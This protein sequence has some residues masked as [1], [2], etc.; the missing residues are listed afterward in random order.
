MIKNNRGFTLIEIMITISITVI[1]MGTVLAMLT[2][3][4]KVYNQIDESNSVLNSA[5]STLEMVREMTFN[6]Q[7]IKISNETIV[8]ITDNSVICICAIDNSIYLDGNVVQ[9]AKG[10][11]ADKMELIFS[12]AN[13]NTNDDK[14]NLLDVKLDITD[15][16]N[17]PLIEQQAISLFLNNVENISGDD[18][19]NCIIITKGDGTVT[20]P[21]I[22]DGSGDEA[23]TVNPPEVTTNA[24]V[25][26][27]A[28]TEAT[29][30]SEV[31]T[32]ET[33]ETTTE[34]EFQG[35]TLNIGNNSLGVSSGSGY[36]ETN[37]ENSYI[38]CE[39]LV[40]DLEKNSA[41]LDDGDY[42]KF[43]LPV[44]CKR[45]NIKQSSGEMMY[46][47]T[48]SGNKITNKASTVKIEPAVAGWYI[49][50]GSDINLN[51]IEFKL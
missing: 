50:K 28:T 38:Y 25:S 48:A 30:L 15:K 20:P 23:T 45:I 49:I 43:Y 39:W 51:K 34:S 47:E 3:S 42:F 16:N 29:T 22:D 9:S 37:K 12:K 4:V 11:K 27:E 8:P 36:L 40:S 18:E 17:N 31:T 33:T 10:S 7:E 19:G 46:I 13:T 44:D 21:T 35:G 26:T 6:A 14:T 41:E 24:G 5:S 32:V 1:I 2:A